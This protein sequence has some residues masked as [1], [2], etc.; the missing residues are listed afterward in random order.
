MSTTPDLSSAE[1][2]KSSYSG[3]GGAN[4]VE[5][6]PTYISSGTVPVR[7][8]KSPHGPALA[9]T[10]DGWAEFVTAVKHGELHRE[11]NS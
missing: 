6:A 3:N 9:F 5:W 4:C 7:D 11:Q 8:S 1:W 10:P 2:V